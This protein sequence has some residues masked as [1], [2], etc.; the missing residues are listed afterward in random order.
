MTEVLIT[1]ANAGIGLATASKFAENGFHVLALDKTIDSP[2]LRAD[3]RITS[4]EFDLQNVGGIA[5]LVSGL[6]IIDVLV[7]NA[8]IINSMTYENYDEEAKRRIMAINLEAPVEMITR[9]AP[10]MI[11]RH[12][13]RIVNI[14]SVNGKIGHSDIWYGI[15]KAGIMNMTKSF[16]KA[17]GPQGILV[18]CVAPGPVDT[19]MLKMAPQDRVRSFID[20][21]I[22]K[23]AATPE[24][25]A[26]VAYWLGTTSPVYMNGTVLDVNDGI[27]L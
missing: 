9:V 2:V 27:R 13:G 8:G 19:A 25:I 21:S 7:N 15:T 5:K 3:A 18:N 4:V 10:G 23:R 1:G 6:G 20:M 22:E 24:E 17:L 26:E 14:S 11:S 16:S 12:S